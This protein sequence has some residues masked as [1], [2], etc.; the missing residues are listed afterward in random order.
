MAFLS[1]LLFAIIALLSIFIVWKHICKNKY[2][3]F[4]NIKVNDLLCVLKVLENASTDSKL[5]VLFAEGPVKIILVKRQNETNWWFEV[6]IKDYSK[7][8]F[9]KNIDETKFKV[10]LVKRNLYLVEIKG[11]SAELYDFI[12][13]LLSLEF[14]TIGDF[15]LAFRFVDTEVLHDFNYYLSSEN[16]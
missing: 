13:Y 5:K 12:I 3:Y 2:C 7:N 11:N 6:K 1:Y 8:N 9:V 14:N 16:N 10:N 4:G 15:V